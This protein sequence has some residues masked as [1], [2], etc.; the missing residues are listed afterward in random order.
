MVGT[1]KYDKQP[2]QKVKVLLRHGKNQQPHCTK[3]GFSGFFSGQVLT[4]WQ[5]PV[6][7]AWT[8]ASP[9]EY[10]HR[11]EL[12]L[13]AALLHEILSARST[14]STDLDTRE[15]RRGLTCNQTPNKQIIIL[16]FDG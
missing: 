16:L 6:W 3:L 14:L 9:T 5:V 4:L 11:I 7:C 1:G 8:A 10:Q 12:H 15:D 13:A 2:I